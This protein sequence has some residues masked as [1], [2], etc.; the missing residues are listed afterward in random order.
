MK[1]VRSDIAE[2][3]AR[4]LMD[5]NGKLLHTEMPSDMRN[6]DERDFGG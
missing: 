6:D 2:L 5:E 3:R 4:G 1:R